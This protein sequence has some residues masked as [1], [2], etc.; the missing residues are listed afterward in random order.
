[1]Y[2]V[3]RKLRI[4]SLATIP[5]I[6]AFS[7]VT[8]MHCYHKQTF[9]IKSHSTTSLCPNYRLM[10]K[11]KLCQNSIIMASMKVVA[12]IVVYEWIEHKVLYTPIGRIAWFERNYSFCKAGFGKWHLPIVYTHLLLWPYT[13]DLQASYFMTNCSKTV[14]YHL[15]HII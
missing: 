8:I 2:Q 12:G 5:P 13:M 14:L 7:T 4:N 3:V 15:I 6:I 9:T 1:M 11:W 10:V